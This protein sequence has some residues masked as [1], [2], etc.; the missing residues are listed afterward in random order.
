MS[1]RSANR[2]I[3]I[4][5]NV[6]DHYV[7]KKVYYPGG[8]ALNVAVLARRFGL[9]DVIYIGILADDEEGKHIR[10]SM[11]SE[12]LTDRHCRLVYGESAK[13]KVSL[14]DGDRIFVGSNHG[15]VR[16][17]LALRMDDPD[18]ELLR[19]GGN[20]HSTCF[21]FI[22]PE[23]ARI[24][25]SVQRLSYDFSTGRDKTY[26]AATCPMV[27]TAF[28]SG[29]DMTDLETEAFIDEAHSFGAEAVC[30][31]QGARGAVFS[32]G[33]SIVRQTIIPA[34]VIDTMGAG[35]AF[36]AGFLSAQIRGAPTDAALLYAATCASQ[37]CTWSG[38]FGYPHPAS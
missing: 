16:R 9:E 30:V 7:D 37:A 14:V 23:L 20:V 35:D 21:S 8:N 29:S 36:I 26:F 5:D 22:E 32:D 1:S 13:A 19:Q 18:L 17:R 31:T 38:A 33:G 6:V 25:S 4:G 28:F 2:L 12:G 15:G 24:R 27:T 34:D 3:S 11:A 10:S